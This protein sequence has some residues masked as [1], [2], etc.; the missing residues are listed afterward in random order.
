MIYLGPDLLKKTGLVFIQ[1]K[2]AG[3]KVNRSVRLL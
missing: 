2:A 3:Y 1:L